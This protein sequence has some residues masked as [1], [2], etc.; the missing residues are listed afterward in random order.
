MKKIIAIKIDKPTNCY[1]CPICDKPSMDCPL[2]YDSDRYTLL[3]QYDNCPMH[4]IVVRKTLSKTIR[5][6]LH[7]LYE[8]WIRGYCRRPCVFCK[9]FDRCEEEYDL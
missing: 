5:N 9:Y 2:Q 6:W 8:K 4:E 3:E 1:N 7:F